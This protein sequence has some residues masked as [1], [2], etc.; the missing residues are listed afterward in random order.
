MTML[1]TFHAARRAGAPLLAIRT[2]DQQATQA[3]IQASYTGAPPPM[4]DWDIVD[5]CHGLNESGAMAAQNLDPG[6]E[7]ELLKAARHL[8][9]RSILFVH[10]APP[11]L[12]SPGFRQALLNLRDQFK[13][14]HRTIVLLGHDFSL[15]ADLSNDVLLLEEALPTEAQLEAIID[16]TYKGAA[17]PPP[18][19]PTMYRAIDA[20]T[21]LPAFPAEQAA[22]MS[23]RETG[24]DLGALWTRKRQMITQAR[25]LSC[26]E[27]RGGFTTLGGLTAIKAYLA[28]M[29]PKI[30]L[31]VLVD[32]IEKTAAAS[33]G[34]AQD[35]GT[36]EDAKQCFLT[37]MEDRQ[38]K[39]MLWPGVPGAGKTA[40]ARALAA[41][42][43]CQFIQFD[44]G[45]TRAGLVGSSEA[46]IRNAF[47]V[48]DAV[49]GDGVLMIATCN[50]MAGLSPELKRRFQLATFY[51]D[52]PTSE[53]QG[54]IWPIWRKVYGIPE[55]YCGLPTPGWT[56]A[57]IR[58]CCMTAD[59]LGCTLTEAA[60]YV[61]PVCRT[62][63]EQI[64]A[65]RREAN[66]RYLSASYPGLYSSKDRMPAAELAA[67]SI[68]VGGVI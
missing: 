67:R 65:L 52:L 64:D 68:Q 21:G 48:I 16:E 32:E 10:G 27:P 43:R 8:P 2:P 56:G 47:N 34:Q 66:G 25:G 38:Y 46:N 59:L 14:D 39:G 22:A 41:E 24:L 15:P 60:G 55:D 9:E 44:I 30:R 4:L 31:V 3:A 18:D 61:V 1:E 54:A 40:L 23:M 37:R 5:G 50:R 51:F 12:T 20:L 35:G 19:Q 6:D 57:E 42:A 36:S 49:G 17:L 26:P 63:A 58:T 62:A 29:L 28:R 33:T 45:A 11:L 7:V 13:A 53:E